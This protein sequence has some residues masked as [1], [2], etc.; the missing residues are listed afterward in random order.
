MRVCLPT[1]LLVMCLPGLAADSQLVVDRGLPQSNLNNASGAARSNVRWSW[2]GHG[3]LGDDFTIGEPGEHW[4][5]DSIRTWAVPGGAGDV[6]AHFGDYY[7]D[8]RLHFGQNDVTPVA[9]GQLTA[10]S[11]DTSNT[12]IRISDTSQSGAAM[13]DD[14]GTSLRVWQ[15]DFTNLNLSVEGGLK[16]RFGVWGNGRP[17]PGAEDKA[18]AWYNHASNAGLSGAR[19]DGADGTM[20]LF[21]A[22]GRSEG[23]HNAE[24][25]GFDKGTDINVQVFA[26]RV[27]APAAK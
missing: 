5:I 22:A 27:E 1:F 4:V 23:S 7:Q 15:I 10:G 20:L 13:Y 14:F 17:I 19:Q 16:Y 8:V 12:N 25:G 24:G 2:R 6:L 21:D 9:T 3:F 11:D 18:F 26:H